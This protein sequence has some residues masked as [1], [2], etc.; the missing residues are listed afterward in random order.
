M[1]EEETII[2]SIRVADSGKVYPGSV[3]AV[4]RRCGADVWISPASQQALASGQVDAVECLP[5]ARV[6]FDDSTHG[7]LPGTAAEVNAWL[8][9]Q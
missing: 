3:V 9:R 6:S 2:A 5:C 8:R 1:N 7:V 4:C